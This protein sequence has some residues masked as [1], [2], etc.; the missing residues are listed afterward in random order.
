MNIPSYASDFITWTGREP[1]QT[2]YTFNVPKRKQTAE[3]S[4]RTLLAECT[5][6]KLEILDIKTYSHNDQY[7]E[8]RYKAEGQLRAYT[9]DDYVCSDDTYFQING[10]T[11]YPD[12]QYHTSRGDGHDWNYNG[13]EKTTIIRKYNYSNQNNPMK[14][15]IYMKC[16]A[17]TR[18]YYSYGDP[19]SA[20]VEYNGYINLNNVPGISSEIDRNYINGN[21]SHSITVKGKIWDVEQDDITIEAEIK[22]SKYQSLAK[23]TKFI[24]IPNATSGQDDDYTFT[25]NLNEFPTDDS[26]YLYIKAIDHYLGNTTKTYRIYIDRIKPT[27]STD[28][29]FVLK[30]GSNLAVTTNEQSEVYL[31]KNDAPYNVYTDVLNAVSND[32]GI[33]VG[34]CSDKTLFTVPNLNGSFRLFAVDNGK[35]VSKPS[36]TIVQIDSNRPE[37]IDIVVEGNELIFIYDDAISTNASGSTDYLLPIESVISSSVCILAD[38]DNVDYEF[39]FD[40]FESDEKYTD[41]FVFS[42]FDNS[43]FTNPNGIPNIIGKTASTKN[44][45]H[46][47]GQYTLEYQAQ[48]TPV[49]ET[50]D[51]FASYRKWGNKNNVQLLVHR[52]PIASL[53]VDAYL[54][55]GNWQIGSFNGEGYDLDHMDM[56]N[57]G[58]VEEQYEWKKSSDSGFTSGQM[59]NNLPAKENNQGI[60]YIIKYRVK[61]VEGAWSKPV[62]YILNF[63]LLFEAKLKTAKNQPLTRVS[64][65]QNLITYEA[66]TTC[67]YN[68]RLTLALYDQNG[69]NPVAGTHTLNVNHQ[70]GVTGTKIGLVTNWNNINYYIPKSTPEN[71]YTFK[72]T[73]ISTDGQSITKEWKVYLINNTPPTI[74]IQQIEPH[75]IYESDQV[76]ANIQVNDADLDTLTVTVN[77]SK[78]GQLLTA[79]G[80]PKTYTLSPNTTNQYDLLEVP[81][82]NHIALGNYDIHVLVD[83]QNGG[84]ATDSI[85]ITPSPLSITGNVDH[86]PQWNDN[87][88]KYNRAKTGKDNEPRDYNMYWAGERFMLSA[89]TTAINAD[90]RVTVTKVSVNIVEPSR[91]SLQPYKKDL[92]PITPHTTGNGWSGELWDNTMIYRWGRPNP[93]DLTFHFTVYYSNGAI[94]YNDVTVTI[95]DRE[96]YFQYHRKW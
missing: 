76:K 3:K 96:T 47:V 35:N 55:N 68:V 82:M 16:Y 85:T 19:K 12:T 49:S 79:N 71:W 90:S 30:G 88:I 87:R 46:E 54:Q 50:E 67:P 14:L 28:D 58:I 56:S 84:T 9:Y 52:R 1:L 38:E 75:F 72:A 86:H 78:D 21:D 83:D 53:S 66:V 42:A 81:L 51:N 24:A 22:D 27:V 41:R 15:H 69:T 33:K 2:Q 40:D 74:N 93:E 25:F 92:S 77:F 63:N 39:I 89:H 59:P 20:Q 61:D 44:G 10:S 36:S 29:T 64:T 43:M 70:Q 37:I 94:K 11:I 45:F 57:K 26:G 32:K 8:I 18:G 60:D 65:D 80:Y 6:I 48:D 17:Y 13:E 34:D 7:W 5:G 23:K 73:A 95:D 62:T 4:G 91:I 31:L